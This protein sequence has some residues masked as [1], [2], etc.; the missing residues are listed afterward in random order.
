MTVMNLYQQLQQLL[1]LRSRVEINIEINN[2]NS[3]S[4]SV[5]KEIIKM[6]DVEIDIL[7]AKLTNK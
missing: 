6:L 3:L 5:H 1:D 4:V 2:R 7:A